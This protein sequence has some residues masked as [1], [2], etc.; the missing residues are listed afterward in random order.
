MTLTAHWKSRARRTAAMHRLAEPVH[1]RAFLHGR[2]YG[3]RPSDRSRLALRGRRLEGARQVVHSGVPPV[4]RAC[5]RRRPPLHDQRVGARPSGLRGLDVRGRRL[6]L[7]RRE[8]RA[9][10]PAVQ[11]VR[12]HRHAQLH[13]QRVGERP[14]AR[15]R[16]AWRG[17]RLARRRGLE[18]P[19]ERGTPPSQSNGSGG[20][21]PFPVYGV[22]PCRPDACPCGAGSSSRR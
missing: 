18:Y 21:S 6:V 20:R 4:Q 14:S 9:L 13:G 22:S 10:V 1:G 2:H 16:L 8:G 5:A 12:A 15:R 17:R 19:E 7:R 11:S 3:A